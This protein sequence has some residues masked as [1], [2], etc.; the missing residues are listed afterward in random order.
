M[1]ALDV[2]IRLP[3]ASHK[4]AECWIK[5]T[6]EIMVMTRKEMTEGMHKRSVHAKRAYSSTA[7]LSN[8]L[9]LLSF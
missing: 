4:F 9:V 1:G 3:V 6:L 7:L 2:R 8:K 5:A